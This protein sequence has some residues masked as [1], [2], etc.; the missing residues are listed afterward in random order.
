MKTGKKSS[1]ITIIL[2]SEGNRLFRLEKGVMAKCCACMNETGHAVGG[3]P[4]C[5]DQTCYDFVAAKAI[6]VYHQTLARRYA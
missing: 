1:G 6:D 3:F 2:I 5:H 4:S